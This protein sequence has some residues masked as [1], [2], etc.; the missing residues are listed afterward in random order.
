MG[1]TNGLHMSG[2]EFSTKL[3]F[4]VLFSFS[5]FS[6]SILPVGTLISSFT[7][8]TVMN[9]TKTNIKILHMER[10]NGFGSAPISSDCIHWLTGQ[11]LNQLAC[12]GS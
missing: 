8:E 9:E 1:H 4:F 5:F 2:R 7:L 11:N 10:R 12:V 6:I 3:D